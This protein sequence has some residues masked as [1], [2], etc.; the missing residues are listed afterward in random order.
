MSFH[1]KYILSTILTLVVLL[2]VGC[3]SGSDSGLNGSYEVDDV[4]ILANDITVGESTRVE[5]FFETKTEVDGLPNGLDVVVRVPPEIAYLPNSSRLYDRTTSES[6]RYDPSDAVFCPGG[7]AYLIYYFTDAD[8]FDRELSHSGQF[9]LKFEVRG[10]TPIG[11]AP[12]QA[13]ASGQGVPFECGKSF[14]FE[15]DE[16]VQVLP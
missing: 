6:D 5:V 10:L 9:G 8:L 16:S 12:I 1:M 11:S 13:A 4:N 14:G 3:G 2:L 7:E 15:Q